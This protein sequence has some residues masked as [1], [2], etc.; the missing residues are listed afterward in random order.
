M[1]VTGQ[2][3]VHSLCRKLQRTFPSLVDSRIGERERGGKGEGGK[4]RKCGRRHNEARQQH[5][6]LNLDEYVL[7]IIIEK[8][9]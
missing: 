2:M 9:K 7:S 1:F 3:E 6:E 4:R 5:A 8:E